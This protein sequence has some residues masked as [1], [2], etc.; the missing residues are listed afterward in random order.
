MRLQKYLA[1]RGVGSRRACEAMIEEGRVCV[2]GQ[3][4]TQMGVQV[5]ENDQIAVDG[6]LV[7]GAKEALQYILLFKPQGVVTTLSD[8]LGRPTVLS[9]IKEVHE[10]VYPVGR[11]DWDTE[12]LLLLT[13]DGELANNLMHPSKEVFKTYRVRA[14]GMLKDEQLERLRGGV[15]LDD[16][17]NTSP[18]KVER[19][20][21]D[22]GFQG[23]TNLLISVHEGH[24]RLIRRMVEAVGSRVT[25]LCRENIGNITLGHMKPGQWR[26]LSPAEVKYLKGLSQ[27]D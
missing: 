16:G 5:E 25:Y 27:D 22:Q 14:K 12:G 19:L 15:T 17:H 4:I 11:L 2:N 24:N 6:K 18:A 8:D 3:V 9:L 26:H 1:E 23:Q 21:Y 13:N 10:R 7:S 20:P